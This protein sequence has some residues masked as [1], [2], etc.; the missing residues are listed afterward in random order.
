[1]GTSSSVSCSVSALAPSARYSGSLMKDAGILRFVAEF[2]FDEL[3]AA[4]L[5]TFEDELIAAGLRW[6][7]NGERHSRYAMRTRSVQQRV[8]PPRIQLE[9]RHLTLRY[10]RATPALIR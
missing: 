5:G 7:D 1:M 3:L 10:R 9:I 4:A 8:E 6:L 2:D